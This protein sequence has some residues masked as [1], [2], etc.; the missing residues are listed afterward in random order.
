VIYNKVDTSC[1]LNQWIEYC[2]KKN[3]IKRHIIYYFSLYILFFCII[4]YHVLFKNR[5]IKLTKT[6]P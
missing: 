3:I 4:I 2:D 6:L 1:V 5:V